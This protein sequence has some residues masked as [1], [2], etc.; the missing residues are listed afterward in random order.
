VSLHSEEDGEVII[1]DGPFAETRVCFAAFWS[2]D[3]SDLDTALKLSAEG[4][5]HCNRRVEVLAFVVQ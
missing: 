3:A 2:I 1:S 5:R 4:S